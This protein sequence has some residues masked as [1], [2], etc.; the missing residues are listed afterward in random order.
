MGNRNSLSSK[1]Q[2]DFPITFQFEE[3]N[4]ASD[5]DFVAFIPLW[6]QAGVK[7]FG[8]CCGTTPRTIS[9]IKKALQEEVAKSQ[10]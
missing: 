3:S 10:L 5:E 2:V 7:F 6:F 4:G 1:V 9:A 8:G